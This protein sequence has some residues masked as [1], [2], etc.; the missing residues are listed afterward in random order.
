V[1]ARIVTAD[2]PV[3]ILLVDDQP[4]KL[5]SY[6]AIL[7]ELGENLV[8]A[9]SARE[10]LERLL[11]TEVA[12]ILIDVVM[13][14][15]D[16]FELAAMIRGHPRF[17]QTAIIFVSAVHMTDLDRLRG[18]EVGA[19]DYVPV[20][21]VPELLRAKVRVFA[22]L[23]RKTRQLE[24]LNHELERRVAERTA[25]LE[26]STAQLRESE[27]R[28][29]IAQET[30]GIGIWDWDLARERIIFI[31]DVYRNWGLDQ[32]TSEPPAS[33]FARVVHPGDRERVWAAIQAALRGKRAY[34]A[35]FRILRPD[36]SVRWLAGKGEVIRDAEGRPARMIGTD[37]D[38]TERHRAAEV[39][40]AANAELERRVEERTREREAALAQV[41]E[42]QKMESLG[43][44][45]GGV[46]HD[47]NNLL[48]AV[49]GNLSLLRKR[50]PQ[51]ARLL[52]LLDGAVQGAER[53]ATLTKRMLAFAR[54]QELKP[55]TVSL[56][57]LVEG[58][59]D[60]LRRSL[61]PVVE[62]ATD[63]LDDLP[64]IRVD[65]NQL[66][67]ALLNLAVNARDAMPLGGRLSI[68]GRRAP[69]GA[70]AP[71]DLLG[72]EYVCIAVADTGTGMDEATLKRATEPFFTT[73]GVGKGTGLGLSMVHGLAAQSGGAMRIASRIG[74]GTTVELWLPVA[75][76]LPAA[77]PSP[78]AAEVE[79]AAGLFSTR[80]C[81][82][83]V[84]DDDP[85]IAAG[86]CALLEDLGHTAVEALSAMRALEFLEA[87]AA[88]DLVLTDH[89]MPGMTGIELAQEIRAKWP[90]LP[91]LLATGYAD[92]AEGEAVDLPRL[93][94]PYKQEELVAHLSRI[95]DRGPAS[96]VVPIDAARRA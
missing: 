67:L 11:R 86:T 15:L 71:A 84:V 89:A 2:E 91:I 16:G 32:G 77:R 24:R 6:E 44:L 33:V 43:K 4:A 39:L 9:N 59:A 34:A 21:V 23:Y 88:V 61:G 13:P 48:M 45:T 92:F 46:A 1:E 72:E 56:V 28:L 94:K 80:A 52:R 76:D 90:G 29:R 75:E 62:I 53:G 60:L 47:F 57:R 54:R 35:E 38:I 20:P 85:L 12:V 87:D 19:V 74:A 63:C 68:T 65:P 41:H 83:L 78:P 7:G 81:R 3:N 49:L 26:A 22:E 10:A 42:M 96:N 79:P 5:L 58:M 37:T 31:G 14:D 27:E 93:A 50:L 25:E 17:E 64:P 95:L 55:E 18:Y 51:D 69:G 70:G 40:E 66:E 82:V 73:K 36:G 30:S 8:R